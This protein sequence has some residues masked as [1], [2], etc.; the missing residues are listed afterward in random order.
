MDHDAEELIAQAE[1]V[2]RRFE[3]TLERSGLSME[4]L[5]ELAEKIRRRLA[6]AERRRVDE[7]ARG[8]A[9]R[10]RRP[11]TSTLTLPTGIRG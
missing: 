5:R 11:G 6:P 7:A 9:P 4:R 10:R 2:Q 3:E 1:D 8:L